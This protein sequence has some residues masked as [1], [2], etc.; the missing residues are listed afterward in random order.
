MP[1]W[2]YVT[3]ILPKNR[4][5]AVT[6]GWMNLNAEWT[7]AVR[8]V[9]DAAEMERISAPKTEGGVANVA[10]WLQGVVLS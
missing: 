3:V 4:L 5:S 7:L 1:G 2:V 8:F 10:P 6:E 9:T